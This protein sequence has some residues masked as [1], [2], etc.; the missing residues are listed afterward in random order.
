MPDLL[1]LAIDLPLDIHAT[2][3][4]EDRPVSVYCTALWAVELQFYPTAA[5]MLGVLWIGGATF[6]ANDLIPVLLVLGFN[7]N[8]RTTK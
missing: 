4:A 3:N 5:A 7:R 2:F 6:R 1:L 8:E